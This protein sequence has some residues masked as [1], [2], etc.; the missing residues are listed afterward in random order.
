M[1]WHHRSKIS[2]VVRRN[3]YPRNLC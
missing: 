3:N 1:I 2:V